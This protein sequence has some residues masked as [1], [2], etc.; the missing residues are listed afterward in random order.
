MVVAWVLFVERGT[1]IVDLFKFAR[2]SGAEQ[3]GAWSACN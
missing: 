3:N 2:G 1:R